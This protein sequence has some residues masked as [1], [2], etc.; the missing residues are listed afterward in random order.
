MSTF[1]G[2]TAP[3]TVT[4]R[5]E[6]ALPKVTLSDTPKYS[7]RLPD[8]QTVLAVSPVFHVAAESL[9]FHVRFRA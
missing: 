5:F 3:S 7:G 4:V 8:S 2:L 9:P 1:A 6:A